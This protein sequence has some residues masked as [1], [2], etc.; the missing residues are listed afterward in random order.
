MKYWGIIGYL[1]K[2]FIPFVGCYEY[3]TDVDFKSLFQPHVVFKD[4]HTA[5]NVTSYDISIW[6]MAPQ[7]T[8]NV[9]LRET[10]WFFSGCACA[11]RRLYLP[12]VRAL[13]KLNYTFK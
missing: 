11:G 3:E 9:F 10:D 12:L 7:N 8:I 2:G 5:F 13:L 4:D 6:T 1:R